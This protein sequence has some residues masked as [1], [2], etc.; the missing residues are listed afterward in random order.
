MHYVA[1][2]P[3]PVEDKATGQILLLFCR[4]SKDVLQLESNDD[5]MTWDN[6]RDI[7]SMVKLPTLTIVA[8]G[9]SNGLQLPSGRF[10]ICA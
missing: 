8:S 5:G 10:V 2:N 7:T 1:D 3:A 9:P 6:M 4:D